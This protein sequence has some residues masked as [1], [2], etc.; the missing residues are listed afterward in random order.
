MRRVSMR[1][2]NQNFSGVMAEV[3][4]GEKFVV[5]KRGKPFAKIVPL[6]STTEDAKRQKAINE[7]FTR[8]GKGLDLGGGPAPT[9]DEMHEW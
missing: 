8:L 3:E 7:F 6:R 1:E 2:A 5:E 4:A 9:K